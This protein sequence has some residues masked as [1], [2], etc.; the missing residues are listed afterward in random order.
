MLRPSAA[1]KTRRRNG[2]VLTL[3]LAGGSIA[4]AAAPDTAPPAVTLSEDDSGFTLAN[5]LLTAR[6]EKRSG[7]L[8]SL[9]FQRLELIAHRGG[10]YWSSV[11]SA[12][13]G[14]HR[15]AGVRLA[16]ATNGGARAEIACRFDSEGQSATAPL[17]VE[18]RY[19]LGRGEHW[20][21]AYALWSHRPGAPAFSVGEARYCV[22]LNPDV[23]DYLTVDAQRRRVM[24]TGYDWDHGTPLNLKEAR[25]LTTGRH[26]GEVEHKYDYSAV[27]SETPAYGWSSTRHGVGLWMINPSQ[28]YIGGGPTKVELTGH[29]DG[30]PGGLPTLLN[31]WLGSHYGGTSLAV[32][33]AE[34]WT[35]VIGPFVLYC[36]AAPAPRAPPPA[37]AD[38]MHRALWKDALDHAAR[39]AERWPY[40][41]VSA[42]DFPPAAERGTVS[43][44]IVL[45]DPLVPLTAISNLQVGLAAPD[46][47]ARPGGR[48][49]F[50]PNVDWQRD[51]KFYEFWT[52][53]DA[54]GRFTL[55]HVRP[56]RYTLHAFA[57]GVLGEFAHTNV[58]VTIAEE[59][60]LGRL[61]WTPVRHGRPLWEIGVPDRTAREF[62]HGD[63]Y[64]QWGLYYDYPREFPRDV[65]FVIGRSDGRRDW[66]YCQPP[67]LEGDRVQSTTWTIQ[68]V[69]PAAGRGRATLRLAIAGSRLPRGIEVNVND[70]A[71]GGTGP[72]PDT[73]VMHRDG[74]RGYWCE[75]SVP[76]D[77][78]L[79]RPGRNV[80]KLRVP[81]TSWVHGVLYDYLRLEL[82]ESASVS[83]RN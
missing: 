7:N 64:W 66:N 47:P 3:A 80:L 78:A 37:D 49:A 12:R 15:T 74:I 19:S 77:A 56:G 27:L 21:Y 50:P 45:R 36:N 75:R 62:R 23:F 30:N 13:L 5:G 25:R 26:A 57:D 4:A 83:Q 24:P 81:A 52:R 63:R 70:T 76:F 67:R 72:L 42:P 61:E 6:I 39:E 29:L 16:P 17:D 35:K 28:E 10:G 69:L 32:G 22:K 40:A 43:G 58:L 9:Q 54:L 33:E 46:Y 82:D 71:V 55:R 14:T 48:G 73:G 41:W 38:D 65:D 18:L 79:L 34:A 31:M 53:A 51:A 2:L 11:G 68:F 44:Q 8:V 20:L 1:V 59:K 60:S